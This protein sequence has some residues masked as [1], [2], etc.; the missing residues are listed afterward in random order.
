MKRSIAMLLKGGAS[1]V[2]LIALGSGLNAPNA[3]AGL[4]TLALLD[5][6]LQL[7]F[8]TQHDDL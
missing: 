8:G 6:R 1:I 3:L 4:W 2:F 7:G 5:G